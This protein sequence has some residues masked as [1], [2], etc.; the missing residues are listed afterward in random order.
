MPNNARDSAVTSRDK[1]GTSRDKQGQGRDKQGQAR[2]N[3]DIH[4]LSLL[5]N[6]LIYLLIVS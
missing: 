6:D 4:F 2:T 3:R 5:D 1:A